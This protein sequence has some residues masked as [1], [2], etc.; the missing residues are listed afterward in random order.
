MTMDGDGDGDGDDDNGD[1]DVDVDVDVDDDDD[2]Y[3]WW[4]V[5][6]QYH[7]QVVALI[8]KLAPLHNANSFRLVKWEFS[9][10]SSSRIMLELFTD[11]KTIFSL[12]MDTFG[13]PMI[14]DIIVNCL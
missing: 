4:M 14:K 1:V 7:Q 10:K 2:D 12:V 8:D 9:S 11:P 13:H 6:S 5:L 3:G